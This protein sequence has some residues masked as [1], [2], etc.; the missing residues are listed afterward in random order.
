MNAEWWLL[1]VVGGPVL[2]GG[3]LVWSQMRARR[4]NRTEDPYRSADDPAKGNPPPS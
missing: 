4:Q 1:A 3:A 2:L